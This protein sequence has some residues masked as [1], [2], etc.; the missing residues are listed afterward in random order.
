MVEKRMRELGL[1]KWLNQGCGGSLVGNEG[2]IK[3]KYKDITLCK[4]M[5]VGIL[6]MRFGDYLVKAYVSEGLKMKMKNMK[7]RMKSKD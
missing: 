1:M 4:R 7:I 5:R 3:Y 6:R 2:N